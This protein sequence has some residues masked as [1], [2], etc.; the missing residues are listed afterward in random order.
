[1]TDSMSR[2]SVG[3]GR[4][5][6]EADLLTA[7]QALYTTRPAAPVLK[8]GVRL[9][10]FWRVAPW[11]QERALVEFGFPGPR[12]LRFSEHDWRILLASAVPM[13]AGDFAFEIREAAAAEVFQRTVELG[14]LVPDDPT[15][16]DLHEPLDPLAKPESLPAPSG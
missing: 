14:Y 1:M 3:G 2:F 5:H 11:E 12:F 7:I 13:G 16:C 8:P 6:S 10:G 15:Q 9:H 4:A